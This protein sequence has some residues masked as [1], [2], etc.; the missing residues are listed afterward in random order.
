[1]RYYLNGQHVIEC[2]GC[3][4]R[5]THEAPVGME[6]DF[7]GW[8]EGILGEHYCEKCY[9]ETLAEIN[10]P[11]DYRQEAMDARLDFARGK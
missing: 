2:D 7:D 1:M 6:I 9:S 11:R 4:A 5:D 8:H 10:R 3:E